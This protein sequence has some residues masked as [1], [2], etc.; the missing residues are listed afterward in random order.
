MLR[1]TRKY[2]KHLVVFQAGFGRRQVH[3][4]KIETCLFALH[5]AGRQ[6]AGVFGMEHLR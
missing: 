1:T 3:K 6:P 5:P 2:Y 4:K